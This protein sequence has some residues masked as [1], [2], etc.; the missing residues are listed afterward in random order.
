MPPQVA[1]ERELVPVARREP[2]PAS[3]R[4]PVVRTI[5]GE[6]DG[7]PLPEPDPGDATR[8]EFAWMTLHEYVPSRPVTYPFEDRDR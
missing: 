4:V 6:A 5:Y 3:R 2:P 7:Q 1:A 8:R